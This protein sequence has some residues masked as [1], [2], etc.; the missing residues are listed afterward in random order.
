[1]QKEKEATIVRAKPGCRI[2]VWVSSLLMSILAMQSHAQNAVS[3]GAPVEQDSAVQQ[4]VLGIIS[5]T[6]W[7]VPRTPVRLCIVGDTRFTLDG[8][9]TPPSSSAPAVVTRKAS[10]NDPTIG[11]ACDALYIGK[12]SDAER[13]Q[14]DAS[15]AGHPILTITDNDS[16]CTLGA[17]FCL[18]TDK[19][20]R[21]AFDMNL[22]SVARS[23]VRVSPKV[24]E[25]ARKRSAP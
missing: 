25:L 9:D 4:V 19:K 16:T 23:G 17:M 20:N 22:D 24:L 12:L 8:T 11:T 21:V 13:Q 18:S 14:V 3:E 1:V 2:G 7:P 5:F 10:A 6:H 15:R